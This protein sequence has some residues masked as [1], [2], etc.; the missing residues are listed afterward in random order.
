MP[1]NPLYRGVSPIARRLTQYDDAVLRDYWTREV[2]APVAPQADIAR[3]GDDPFLVA[4]REIFAP[5]RRQPTIASNYPALHRVPS[6]WNYSLP[7]DRCGNSP[8]TSDEGLCHACLLWH[9]ITPPKPPTPPPLSPEEIARRQAER[10]IEEAPRRWRG[11]LPTFDRA[12]PH[13]LKVWHEGEYD[14]TGGDWKMVG[15]L[16]L[17]NVEM[18]RAYHA[19]VER[20]RRHEA[21]TDTWRE[22]ADDDPQLIFYH[23]HTGSQRHRLYNSPAPLDTVVE[24]FLRRE[25][26]DWV[27]CYERAGDSYDPQ[28]GILRYAPLYRFRMLPEVEFDGRWRK[29]LPEERWETIPLVREFHRKDG[30]CL[31]HVGGERE[32]ILSSPFIPEKQ[33]LK[34]RR[35]K[36]S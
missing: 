1:R 26:I 34:L 22:M 12:K 6:P 30:G 24:D 29:Y 31:L 14:D 13:F 7:C 3:P 18:I 5:R 8:A 25:G 20:E 32:V 4:V 36:P 16:D 28:P 9:G 23:A 35:A 15:K 21:A 27:V 33:A 2:V 11:D 10:A 17:A 19:D